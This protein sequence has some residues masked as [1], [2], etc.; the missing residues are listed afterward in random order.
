MQTERGNSFNLFAHTGPI[1]P[2]SHTDH[3][4]AA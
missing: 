2:T 1:D 4:V 3:T